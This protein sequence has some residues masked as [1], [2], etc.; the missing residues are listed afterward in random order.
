M[1]CG[2]SEYERDPTDA[3]DGPRRGVTF[4]TPVH[5][6]L[7]DGFSMMV[8][9][10]GAKPSPREVSPA[11]QRLVAHLCLSGS[12]P[13][14]Q[15]AGHLWPDVSE[16]LARGSLRSALWRLQHLV[17]GLVRVSGTAL[18]LA[19]DVRVDVR[20]LAEWA[21]RV[22]DPH[23]HVDELELPGATLGSEL[24]PGWYE[25]WILLERDRLRQLRLHSLEVLAGRLAAAGR[26]GDALQ[27]AYAAVRVE[28]L[29]ES[30]HRTV[31][32]VHLAEGNVVEAVRAYDRFRVML[33]AEMAVAPTALMTELIRRHV[34]PAARRAGAGNEPTGAGR[35]ESAAEDD[36]R[37]P[38]RHG[39]DVHVQ[40]GARAA[41]P[42]GQDPVPPR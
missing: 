15:V 19:D 34:V 32:R 16:E 37:L 2:F 29:R 18:S 26:H 42:A 28:P 6:R 9:D 35:P 25:D 31:V 1:V 22:R 14:S 20:E 27:V 4:V 39:A 8:R 7:L 17:P 24:L 12:P 36:P 38:G 10:R 41:R 3:S 40:L 13:R 30:A 33:E 23:V 21:R 11:L 5:I